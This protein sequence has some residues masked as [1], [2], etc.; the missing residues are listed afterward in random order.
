MEDAKAAF[1]G[2]LQQSNYVHVFSPERLR[3]VIGLLCYV[4]LRLP[5]PP[6]PS[7]QLRPDSQH[8]EL[9]CIKVRGRR[10]LQRSLVLGNTLYSMQP[11]LRRATGEFLNSAA[12]CPLLFS[13]GALLE[14]LGRL[15]GLS[16]ARC[17]V[18]LCHPR[19]ERLVSILLGGRGVRPRA[20]SASLVLLERE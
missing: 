12:S 8:R 17:D 18:G 19:D 1:F 4:M 10:T 20:V 11:Q 5:P 3:P 2:N 7:L 16:T 6:L 15:L 9:L 14:A 13:S